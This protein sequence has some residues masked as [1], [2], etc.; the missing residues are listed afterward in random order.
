ML[1]LEIFWAADKCKLVQLLRLDR[2]FFRV[3]VPGGP[4]ESLQGYQE[5]VWIQQTKNHGSTRNKV[6]D[7]LT[8]VKIHTDENA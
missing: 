4:P 8:T 2:G 3:R 5:L 6:L 7:I 1:D